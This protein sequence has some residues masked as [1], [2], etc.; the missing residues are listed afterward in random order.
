MSYRFSP[1]TERIAK[2]SEKL[3][4]VNIGG[5]NEK[6]TRIDN[7]EHRCRVLEEG[8]REFSDNLEKKVTNL[9]EEV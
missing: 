7:A 5:D 6:A 2:I 4:L 8:F 1:Q 9:K 3:N